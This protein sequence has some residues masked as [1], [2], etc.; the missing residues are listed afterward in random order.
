MP[1]V[2]EDEKVFSAAVKTFLTCGY[3]S[4]TIQN[5][6]KAADVHEATLYRKYGTK[7]NLIEKA[8]QFQLAETPLDKVIYTGD[9]RADLE[10]IVQAQIETDALYGDILS[11]LLVEVPLYEE[12]KNTLAKPLGHIG[13]VAN[14][15]ARYQMQGLLKK[16]SPIATVGVL[17]GPIIMKSMFDRALGNTGLLPP[18][19]YEYVDH[20]LHGKGT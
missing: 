17:L 4:A 9:L 19:P 20:F 6:A 13:S 12:L 5:I 14:I 7:A 2:I 10:A 15:I 11:M 16:E 8:I 3:E 1:K 18:D